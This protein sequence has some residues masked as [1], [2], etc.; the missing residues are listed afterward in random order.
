MKNKIE[1][2]QKAISTHYDLPPEFFASFLGP[3]MAYSCGYFTDEDESLDRAEENKLKLTSEKLELNNGEKLLDIGS[4]WGSMLFY[5]AQNYGCDVTGISLAQ[6]QVNFVNKKA[7][8]TG[9][10]GVRSMVMHA[11]EMDFEENNFDKVVTIGAIEHMEDLSRVFRS[12][13]RIM[14]DDGLFLVHGMT[15][16]WKRRKEEIEG[17]YNEAGELVKKHFGIG[18]WHSLFEI[19][20]SLEKEGFE[21]LDVENI[22]KHY[23]YT[24]ERWLENLEKKEKEI[25]GK[26]ISEDKY[27]EFIAFMASYIVGFEFG[28]PMCQQ[29]L[30]QKTIPGEL[31]PARPFLRKSWSEK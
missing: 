12:V 21:V 13:H 3:R 27:R 26:I 2:D 18:F 23:Q 22:T 9:L 17:V 25:V 10:T 24:V 1:N 31:R 15:L 20:E 4:G 14:K 8:S 6:E 28:S 5:A 16:P 11:Y 19:I 7:K 29:I 30:C